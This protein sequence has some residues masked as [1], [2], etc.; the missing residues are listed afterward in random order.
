[1]KKTLFIISMLAIVACKKENVDPAP[2]QFV[3]SKDSS[4]AAAVGLTTAKYIEIKAVM[5]SLSDQYTN[6]NSQTDINSDY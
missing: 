2:T 5:K 6:S 1:M 4:E 3:I